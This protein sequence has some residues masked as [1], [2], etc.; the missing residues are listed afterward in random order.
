MVVMELLG[1]WLGSG[2]GKPYGGL[3]LAPNGFSVDEIETC[4]ANL[5]SSHY[6][7]LWFQFNRMIMR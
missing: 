2:K 4:P 3:T 6:G 7:A 1:F 5:L